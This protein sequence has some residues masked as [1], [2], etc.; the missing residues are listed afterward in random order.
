MDKIKRYF[1][2]DNES[3]TGTTFFIRFFAGTALVLFLE[4]VNHSFAELIVSILLLPIL[5]I[6]LWL[7]SAASYKRGSAFKWEKSLKVICSI[8]LP[9]SPILSINTTGTGNY[10]YYAFLLV[11]VLFNILLLKN[12][13][14]N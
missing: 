9:F 12:G 14:K 2:F 4:S 6:A 13:N 1:S 10:T 5:I 8:L 11:A 7:I 3:I